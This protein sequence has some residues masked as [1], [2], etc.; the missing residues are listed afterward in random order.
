[1]PPPVARPR[2]AAAAR[3]LL[4]LAAA[5]LAPAAARTLPDPC[6]NCMEQPI[7]AAPEP[8]PGTLLTLE[9][10]GSRTPPPPGAPAV[11]LLDKLAA[12][13]RT[14]SVKYMQRAFLEVQGKLIALGSFSADKS[15]DTTHVFEDPSESSSSGSSGSSSRPRFRAVVQLRCNERATEE[16]LLR[17]TAAA[18]VD[19]TTGSTA[20]SRSLSS[21]GGM[22]ITFTF[23]LPSSRA[24]GLP[25][26]ASQ[27]SPMPA[28]EYLIY[29]PPMVRQEC[30]GAL[31]SVPSCKSSRSALQL[32]P[33]GRLSDR[34]Q[35]R[36]V[37]AASA[38]PEVA[39]AL[40]AGDGI[41]DDLVGRPV[42]IQ[43]VARSACGCPSHLGAGASRG[44]AAAAGAAVGVEQLAEEWVVE[45]GPL[46]QAASDAGCPRAYLCLKLACNVHHLQL[47]LK[48]EA[49]HSTQWVVRPTDIS[50]TL[51]RGWGLN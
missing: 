11:P 6:F 44:C 5:V 19:A 18:E 26:C 40:A 49:G 38:V 3:L 17:V 47:C 29:K 7:C 35:W 2:A 32:A 13:R 34:Q 30:P 21:Q 48:D 12:Q 45:L 43:S 1:M 10:D 25:P 46:G 16:R 24:C 37:S 42:F 15:N 39:A 8:Q 28:G 51:A 41:E 31:L 14:F 20:R 22:T 36:I 27:G 4:A 50:A 9:V 33:L 23:L